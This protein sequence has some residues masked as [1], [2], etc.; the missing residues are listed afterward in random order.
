MEH[1]QPRENLCGHKSCNF[2]D[3]DSELKDGGHPFLGP[4]PATAA[5]TMFKGLQSGPAPH[6]HLKT[7]NLPIVFWVI[8]CLAIVAQTRL[9]PSCDF[10]LYILGEYSIW[11]Q[12]SVGE[13]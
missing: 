13:G 6:A 8:P 4:H 12:D 9:D 5:A 2:P 1:Y 10:C 3:S 11:S 7:L